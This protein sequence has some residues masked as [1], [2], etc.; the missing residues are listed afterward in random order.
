MHYVPENAAKMDKALQNLD[1]D[2]YY[3]STS[4][5]PTIMIYNTNLLKAA[6]APKNW[7]DLADPK[8]KNKA[9]ISHPGYSGSTGS[10]ALM[11]E[12]LYGW[13]FF[14]KLEKNNPQIGRSLTDPISVVVSGERQIGIAPYANFVE[15]K[16]KGNPIEV[17]FPTDGAKLTRGP[18][19]ILANA[20]HPN[21]AKLFMEFL[22][23]VPGSEILVGDGHA[24]LR[25][26]VAPPP[27]AKLISEIKMGPMSEAEVAGIPE[28]IER[29]RTTF[30]N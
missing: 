25:P 10:W 14:D 21:T 18:T 1:P 4:A 17:I 13:Q 16:A 29:W 5:N 6:E 19:F 27:G 26:E 30:G 9:A 24:P 7:T 22:L 15:S 3:Y 11:M 12:K 2:G 28:L 23:S 8:W 20:P